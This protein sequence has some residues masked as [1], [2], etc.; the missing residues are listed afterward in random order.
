MTVTVNRQLMPRLSDAPSNS[1]FFFLRDVRM[2]EHFFQSI[3]QMIDPKCLVE[4]YVSSV[5]DFAIK[6]HIDSYNQYVSERIPTII[7]Q[8]NPYTVRSQDDMYD[9]FVYVGGEDSSALYFDRPV[10][11]KV[12]DPD[13]KAVPMTPQDARMLG[14]TYSFELKADILVKAVHIPTGDVIETTLSK[15]H[16]AS[17][18][19][20]LRSTMCILNGCS[21]QQMLDLGEC[22]YDYGGYFI[23]DG[24]EKV[25]VTQEK[26]RDH[27]LF[28]MTKFD[29]QIADDTELKRFSIRC[30]SEED[31]LFPKEH[32]FFVYHPKHRTRANA[33]V[34]RAP[35]TKL[36][37]D[38]NSDEGESAYEKFPVFVMFRALGVETD[39]DIIKL[40]YPEVTCH[41]STGEVD[42]SRVPDAPVVE[43]HL[44]ACAK[45][46]MDVKTQE[47]AL[48][49]LSELS[50]IPTKDYAMYRLMNDFV[51]HAGKHFGCKALVF[52]DLVRTVITYLAT[53]E[54]VDRDSM[55]NKRLD[56]TG[57]LMTYITRDFLL[58]WRTSAMSAISQEYMYGAWK[59]MGD[60]SKL[61]N[62]DNVTSVFS[63]TYIDKMILGN[64]K[65]NKQWAIRKNPDE[66]ESIVQDLKRVS[67][68]STISHLRRV[69]TPIDRLIRVT[70]P[71]ELHPTHWGV[72][73]PTET[74][75]G[76]NVGLLKHLAM[77]VY[78]TF[79]IGNEA[80]RHILTSECD[81]IELSDVYQKRNGKFQSFTVDHYKVTLNNV[82]VGILPDEDV[83][84]IAR[85]LRLRRR[86]GQLSVMTSIGVDV[87]R[88]T[89]HIGTEQG[90]CARPLLIV[91]RGRLVWEDISAE[92]VK[93]FASDW[94]KCVHP[95]GFD[96]VSFS[97]DNSHT[98]ISHGHR[99]FRNKRVLQDLASKMCPVEFLDVEETQSSAYVA[100]TP[101]DIS[102]RSTHCELHPMTIL[103]WNAANQPFLHH[104]PGARALNATGNSKQAVGVYVSTFNKRFD[105]EGYVLSYAQRPIISTCTARYIHQLSLPAGV[106][107]ML[108]VAPFTGYNQEDAMI[109]NRNSIERGAL[110]LT[111]YHTMVAT[112][113]KTAKFYD[114]SLEENRTDKQ[115]MFDFS[116]VGSDGVISIGSRIYDRTAIFAIHDRKTKS[117]VSILA[118]KTIGGI[119]DRVNH[120]IDPKT[121]FRTSCVVI[122][123]FRN[124]TIGDKIA[125][126]YY[127]KGIVAMLLPESELPFRP[128]DGCVPD[129]IMNTHALPSRMTVG[130][131][132]ESVLSSFCCQNGST[133]CIDP[134][135]QI[136]H[137]A[138][139]APKGSEFVC[140]RTGEKYESDM[141]FGP[142]FCLRMKQQV[143]DKIGFRS[144]G[145]VD[146]ITMQGLRG[147]SNDG[148]MRL[149]NMELNAIWGHGIMNFLG[150]AFI[151]KADGQIIAYD[152]DD[153]MFPSNRGSGSKFTR[154]VQVPRAF[155]VLS[156]EIKGLGIDIR[157]K[158]T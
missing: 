96:E 92:T 158:T 148:A 2:S 19:I 110:A 122:R 109:I 50:V 61:V 75:D 25:I 138:L 4:C 38:G 104:I 151:Q 152:E 68:L 116:N 128:N 39:R 55:C 29:D 28:T 56:V 52:A 5:S 78:V 63:D 79:D 69:N 42:F 139:Q 73:C 15:V 103:G 77:M 127:Q 24:K 67:H 136:D 26:I 95:G 31:R 85:Y 144:Y 97:F 8:Y 17:I 18:P 81:M 21:P 130:Q 101:S 45:D 105:T 58:R 145:P 59:S 157:V 54:Q 114:P 9:F 3:H 129:I 125:L 62:S 53:D 27:Q 155:D 126:R 80:V 117:D 120:T 143:C 48:S 150:E 1:T 83:V 84:E 7:E 141:L 40:L 65:I 90:R 91:E 108:L 89:L 156:Q 35:N 16:I 93:S 107:L 153:G 88:R 51:P 82:W 36:K 87:K 30:T 146:S 121:G 71:H 20:L 113:S 74:P 72:L 118:D 98:T 11:R 134:L 135:T 154:S 10:F 37:S 13:D 140:P 111:A 132:L 100:M 102:D 133:M 22:R 49:R 43:A 119:V 41:D 12:D 99:A 94:W 60:V 76:A 32:K 112:E 47:D 70:A 86:C 66:Q 57:F 142:L 23:I 64:F 124:C 14:V 44:R 46:A 123:E 6:H 34:V 149:G 147:R 33:I 115:L 131:L 106:N 137:P